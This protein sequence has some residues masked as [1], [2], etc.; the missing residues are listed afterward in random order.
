MFTGSSPLQYRRIEQ[1]RGGRPL[2][3]YYVEASERLLGEALAESGW[4]LRAH[5]ENT[6][7]NRSQ[8]MQ[9]FHKQERPGQEDFAARERLRGAGFAIADDEDLRVLWLA[10]Y[11]LDAAS[12][13]PFFLLHWF[14]DPHAPYRPARELPPPAGLPRD[15]GFY[16]NL[17]HNNESGRR[18]LREVAGELTAA[19]V[20]Y[21][22]QLYLGEVEEV[23]RRVG[24]VLEALRRSRRLDGTLIVFTADHGEEFGEHGG[25][26]HDHAMYDE[27]VRVPLVFAGPG[28]ASG[29]RIAA[30]VSHVDLVPTLADLLQVPGFDALDGRSLRQQLARGEAPRRPRSHYLSSPITHHQDALVWERYKLIADTEGERCELY[31]LAADPRERHD[32]AAGLPAVVA[33]LRRQIGAERTRNDGLWEARRAGEDPVERARILRETEAKLRSIGYIQ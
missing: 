10:D 6:V 12:P 33:R 9:G 7:A 11:L 5:V 20:D 22:R 18:N 31:D 2:P 30:P 3:F 29:R 15:A 19:E 13:S 1:G 25:F 14:D 4:E 16:R 21:V 23:D 17:A 8:A 28:V 27:L 24:W 26:L 32:L